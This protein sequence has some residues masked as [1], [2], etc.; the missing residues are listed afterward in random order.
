MSWLYRNCI[1]PALFSLESE[2]IH[3]RT[4]AALGWASRHEIVCEAA[5]TFSSPGST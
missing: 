3:N 4:L 1:R 2:A 5:T